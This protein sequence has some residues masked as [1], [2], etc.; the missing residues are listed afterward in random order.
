MYSAQVLDHFQN[1]RNAGDIADADAMVEIEN[2]GCGDVLRLSLKVSAGR[3]IAARFKAKGC[4]AA[5]ACG[6]V[7]TDLVVGKTLSEARQ[8]RRE[9]VISV[10]D[11]LPPASTHAAQ[12]ALDALSGALSLIRQ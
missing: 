12:L 5:M 6:S 11:S 2:P 1:P 7:L 8:L 9:D 10:V 4:V 3:I